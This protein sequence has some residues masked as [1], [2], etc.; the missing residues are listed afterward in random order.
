[1]GAKLMIS[2]ITKSITPATAIILFITS[3]GSLWGGGVCWRVWCALCDDVLQTDESG[4]ITLDSA[5]RIY[6]EFAYSCD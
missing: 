4:I 1:M 3:L 6:P 2:K 5:A